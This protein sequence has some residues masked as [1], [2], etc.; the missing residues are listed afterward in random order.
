MA[1]LQ[2]HSKNLQSQNRTAA[3]FYTSMTKTQIAPCFYKSFQCARS[4]PANF[5][6]E[7]DSLLHVLVILLFSSLFNEFNSL[8]S[9]GKS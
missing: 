4:S 9:A 2:H 3:Y 7:I 5:Y 6:P 1:A 8:F